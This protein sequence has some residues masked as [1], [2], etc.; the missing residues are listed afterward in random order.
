MRFSILGPVVLIFSL[1]GLWVKLDGALFFVKLQFLQDWSFYLF[2]HLYTFCGAVAVLFC[3]WLGLGP[4]GKVRIGG[5]AASPRLAFGSWFALSLCTT[6]AVGIL[7][8]AAAEPLIHSAFP[9]QFGEVSPY[10]Y[11]ANQLSLAIVLHHWTLVPYSIYTCATVMFALAIY[12]GRYPLELSAIL[13]LSQ[14]SVCARLKPVVD[15]LCLITLTAGMSANLGVGILMISGVLQYFGYTASHTMETYA[16]IVATLSSLIWA[17]STS[18]IQR[19]M[20]WLSWVNTFFLLLFLCTLISLVPLDRV[21]PLQ[22]DGVLV[23]LRN[24]PTWLSRDLWVSAQDE[25][26]QQWTMF[27]WS[28]WFAWAPVTGLFLARLAYGYT[29]RTVL[30][31]NLLA[32]AFVCG[33][34]MSVFGSIS[35]SLASEPE[36][37]LYRILSKDH[38]EGVMFSV[39]QRLWGG[40]ILVMAFALLAGISFVTAADSNTDT[41]SRLTLRPGVGDGLKGGLG[42]LKFLWTAFVGIIAC[43]FLSTTG[44]DG[45]KALSQ[46]GGVPAVLLIGAG[47]LRL[48]FV[49]YFEKVSHERR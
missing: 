2:G 5:V 15:V 40:D 37:V 18:G 21:L 20:R 16:V 25:W 48:L 1:I 14:R 24:F 38:P 10:S 27:Y 22:S 26:V 19:G 45:I 23:F 12:N 6:I 28:N 33:V 9:P 42:P 8:W 7:F 4:L 36:S 32:P 3:A 43:L 46:L 13:R 49:V 17:S 29:I 30:F 44:L 41:M 35:L 34:W 47:M 11:P 39:L 31:C